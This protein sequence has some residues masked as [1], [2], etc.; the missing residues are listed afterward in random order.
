MRTSLMIAAAL[1]VAALSFGVEAASAHTTDLPARSG[2]SQF[3]RI[4]H[5]RAA[6]PGENV[7]DAGAWVDHT[8]AALPGE[9]VADGGSPNDK[10]TG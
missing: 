4:D 9:N 6:L 2:Q 3:A 5:T 1:S 7:A 8:R 10:Q